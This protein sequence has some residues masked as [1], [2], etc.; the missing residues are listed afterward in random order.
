MSTTIKTFKPACSE[1][2][3]FLSQLH[4]RTIQFLWWRK[5]DAVLRLIRSY[6]IA[7]WNSDRSLLQQQQAENTGLEH[8][9]EIVESTQTTRQFQL[10]LNTPWNNNC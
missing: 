2:N 10:R 4:E 1:G 8:V 5:H 3:K 6:L 9:L 7:T